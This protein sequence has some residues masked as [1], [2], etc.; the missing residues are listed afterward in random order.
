[1]RPT[2]ALILI[3]LGLTGTVLWLQPAALAS[4]PVSPAPDSSGIGLG[5]QSAD[6]YYS[7]LTDNATGAALKLLSSY[8]ADGTV[9]HA[10]TDDFGFGLGSLDGASCGTW[11]SVAPG[12][13]ETVSTYFVFD[14]GG[15]HTATA[16]VRSQGVWPTA[17]PQLG[18]SGTITY[19]V[20]LYLP[21]QNPAVEAPALPGYASGSG[22]GW[23]MP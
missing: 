16:Y 6:T 2:T 1:M 9:S 7:E 4:A 21:S 8:H 10:D 11:K 5:F 14:T 23:R 12:V 13:F 3:V 17:I 20:D 18:D 15:N 22:Q 19:T